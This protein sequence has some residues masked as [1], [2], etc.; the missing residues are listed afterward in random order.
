MSAVDPS[1]FIVA[2]RALPAP[3]GL[4]VRNFGDPKVFKF[5]GRS[6]AGQAVTELVIHESVTRSALSTVA[7]LKRRTLGVHLI[8]APDGKITQHGDLAHARLAHAGGHNGPSIGVEVV[9]P[10]YPYL[11]RDDLPWTRTIAAPWAHGGAYVLPTPAQAEATAQLVGWLTSPAAEGLSIPRAW[12]G[13]GSRG[14]WDR[15]DV[16]ALECGCALR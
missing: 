14:S 9:N 11:L 7:V 2:G 1:A 3:P 16:G 6:R 4:D 15:G 5:E 13:L 10:Y 12:I 8:L